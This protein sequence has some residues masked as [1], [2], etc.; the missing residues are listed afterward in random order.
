MYGAPAPGPTL[1]P[2]PV[3]VAFDA[4]GQVYV[5][6]QERAR[7]LV[8]DR[9]GKIIRTIGSR[10]IG[11]GQAAGA[12]GAGD[13]RG[14]DAL[15]RRHRQRADRPLQRRWHAP[16]LLRALPRDPRDRGVAGRQPRVRG[17]RG[18]QPHHGLDRDGRGPGGDRLD[19]LRAGSAALARRDRRRRRGQPLGR[20]SRQRADAGLLARRRAAAALRRARRGRR[21]VRRAD[22]RQRRLPRP[23]HRRR[24]RQQ[25]RPAVPV[26]SR[27]CLRGAPR[28][29]E[30]AGPDPLQPARSGPAR[31]RGEGDAHDGPVRD[32]PVPAARELRP[33]L[34]GRG[35]GEAHT[36]C[37]QEEAERDA[38]A[39]AVAAGGQDGHGPAAAVE[40][41]RYAP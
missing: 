3:A 34:Q 23:R 35:D 17:G 41:R 7:V 27:E 15:R 16:R 20:R 10:G 25:P 33:A 21:A 30:P 32:P 1:L 18:D 8:F 22:R 19:G 5:L 2:A 40:R 4:A 37:G 14:R 28:G 11:P 12:V 13:L 9:A 38:A 29:P 26:R 6:D 31:G 39:D 24:L 36:A